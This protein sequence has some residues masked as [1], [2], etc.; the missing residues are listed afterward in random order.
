LLFQI[1]DTKNN[2]PNIFCESGEVLPLESVLK[3]TKTWKYNNVLREYS[4]NLDYGF[5]AAKGTSVSDSCPENLKDEWAKLES[6]LKAYYKSFAI[7]KVSLEENCFYD[8]IPYEFT[9]KYFSIKNEITDFTLSK[10]KDENYRFLCRVHEMLQEVSS[11]D[12]TLSLENL[13]HDFHKAKTRSFFKKIKNKQTSSRISYNMFKSKTGRLT[14]N[15]GTFPI[16]N[17]DKEHRS[18]IEPKNDLFVELDY[19]GAEIR[20]LLALSGNNQPDIDIHMWNLDNCTSGNITREEAKEKF[21]AW[22]YNPSAED[23]MLQKFYDKKIYKK[24][25]NGRKIVTPY[26]RSIDCGEYHSLNYLIQSTTSDMVLENSIKV[27]ESLKMLKSGIS[28][29]VHDSIVI[30]CYREDI[31]S[32]KKAIKEFSETRFGKFNV[33]VKIGKNYGTMETVEWK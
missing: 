25:W 17:L 16:L 12:L 33:T 29:L 19:N 21:F 27:H 7:S 6:R 30:D 15:K 31:K 3:L 23:I 10:V 24:Y 18:I 14:T 32:I 22:L 9:Q 20:T 8:L 11:S 4:G 2:C 5:V 1:I 13:R 26:G 28:F